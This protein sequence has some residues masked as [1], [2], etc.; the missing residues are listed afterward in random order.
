MCAKAPYA[1]FNRLVDLDK[2]LYEGDDTEDYLQS[3]LFNAVASTI[4]KLRTF[5]ILRYMQHLNR[6]VDL[7]QILCGGHVIEYCLL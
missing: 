1:L 4:R 7:D 2:I 6:L 3:T 5:K